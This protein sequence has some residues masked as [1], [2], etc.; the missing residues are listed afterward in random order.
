[1]K[2]FN[3]V[4]SQTDVDCIMSYNQY[5]LQNTRLVDDVLPQLKPKGC[6]RHECRSVCGA[7]VDQC[8]TTGWHKDSAEVQQTARLAAQLC[9]RRGVDIAKLALQFSCSHP[10]LA[11]TV[12]GSANPD[13][14][15]KWAEW[16]NEPIDEELLADVL[17]ILQPVHNI[18]HAEGLPENN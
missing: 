17:Q 3:E 2:M 14:I 1:M 18:S 9:E 6:R 10:D 7:T 11:T 13:N 15:R 5:T 4:A 8:T 16:I 12:A